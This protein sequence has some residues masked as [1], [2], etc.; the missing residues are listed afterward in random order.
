MLVVHR[1]LS[2]LVQSVLI[3]PV[4]EVVVG[5]IP[6]FLCYR[7]IIVNFGFRRI[8]AQLALSIYEADNVSQIVLYLRHEWP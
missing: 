5:F 1:L 8:N 2:D 6:W 3:L 7:R 4:I